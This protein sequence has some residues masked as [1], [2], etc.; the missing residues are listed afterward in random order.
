MNTPSCDEIAAAL[1][2][3]HMKAW[4]LDPILWNQI[5][6]SELPCID[7]CPLSPI[8]KNEKVVGYAFLPKSF[9]D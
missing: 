2:E 5:E 7:D 8:E 1:C 4:G 3:D 9:D 6:C